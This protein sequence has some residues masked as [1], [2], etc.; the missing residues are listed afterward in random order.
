MS[1]RSADRQRPGLGRIAHSSGSDRVWRRLFRSTCS[2]DMG[3]ELKGKLSLFPVFGNVAWGAITKIDELGGKVVTISGPDGYIYDPSGI[4]T[5]IDTCSIFVRQTMMLLSLTPGSSA[6]ISSP[7][8]NPGSKSRYR[9][10]LVHVKT[11][12][13]KP[14]PE[15]WLQ[16]LLPDW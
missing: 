8:Q 13:M 2:K 16:W 4:R 1:Y 9:N 14:M 12:L 11:N 15:N 7:M 6:V 5:Q 10:Y 3:K